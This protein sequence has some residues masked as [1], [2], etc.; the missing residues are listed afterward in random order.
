MARLTEQEIRDDERARVLK[1][2][3]LAIDEILRT[4]NKVMHQAL[5]EALKLGK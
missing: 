2:V 3:D 4:T 1:E 5:R